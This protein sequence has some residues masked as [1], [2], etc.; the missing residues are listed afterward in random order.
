MVVFSAQLLV[1]KLGDP[2]NKR[3]TLNLYL[4]KKKI[5]KNSLREKE[6]IGSRFAKS[7][8]IFAIIDLK[9][10]LRFAKKRGAFS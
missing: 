10:R 4:V 9:K 2:K 6:K 5:L 7:G 3:H 8:E 1:V